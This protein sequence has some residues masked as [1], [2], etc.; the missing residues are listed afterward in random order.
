MSHYTD[1]KDFCIKLYNYLSESGFESVIK[2]ITENFQKTEQYEIANT[3]AQIYNKIISV[4]EQLFDN[5]G[6]EKLNPAQLHDMLSFAFLGAGVGIIPSTVDKVSIGD[7]SRMQTGNIKAVFSLGANEG[8]YNSSSVKSIFT[9]D[10]RSICLKN[11]VELLESNEYQ[12]LKNN[13]LLYNL[14]SKSEEYLF[15]SRFSF[16]ENGE[17]TQP[18]IIF[19]R[20]F[21][22]IPSKVE[23]ETDI[24]LRKFSTP[25]AA[26]LS[27]AHYWRQ[28]DKSTETDKNSKLFESIIMY[29][30]ENDL[31]VNELN[32]LLTGQNYTNSERITDISTY[33][34]AIGQPFKA[35]VSTLEK[36]AACPFSFFTEYVLKPKQRTERNIKKTDVGS[37]LHKAIE[38]LSKRIISGEL[39]I[40]HLSEASLDSEIE[41]LTH[42]VFSEYSSRLASGISQKKYLLNR[43]TN[44]VISSTKE[45]IRQLQ[46]SD[47]KIKKAET[48]FKQDGEYAPL[49][50]KTDLG[51]VLVNG[52]IDRIDLAHENSSNYA[53][54]IDYKTSGQNFD[55]I[56][57]YHG[58]SIQ[59]PVYLKAV[60]ENNNNISGVGM[61]Y[62][63]LMQ[64]PIRIKKEMSEDEISKEVRKTFKLNGMLV[65]DLNLI[66]SMDKNAFVGSYIENVSI[67]DGMV[68][69]NQNVLDSETFAKVIGHTEKMIT[70]HAEGILKADINISPSC[71]KLHTACTYCEY[72]SICKFSED[73]DGNKVRYFK[74]KNKYEL[75]QML[76]E[77]DGE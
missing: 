12:R 41:Q 44:A 38:R 28:I 10:D 65:N 49:L 77:S 30:K 47:F 27:L 7:I 64:N 37:I 15:V 32:M 16:D 68:Q 46:L 71:Y 5:F 59:L 40:N 48:F 63:R 20:L 42:S 3:Y 34:M 19:E 69:D 33:K 54:I 18:S 29:L 35:S 43:L 17:S 58:L 6:E 14:L 50:I 31:F 70:K 60:I 53:R 2:S 55:L 67:K 61:F 11:G 36:Y 66:V 39:D 51:D 52:I 22:I 25:K 1:T 57:T 72:K 75:L 76:K 24:L 8:M 9:D 45:I 4:L 13:F 56:K 21:S 74:S 23:S 26:F 62:F 73:F